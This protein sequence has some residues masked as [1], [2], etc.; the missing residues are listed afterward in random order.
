MLMTFLYL[1]ALVYSLK[2]SQ[3]GY[4]FPSN[5]QGQAMKEYVDKYDN[6]C[7]I[8]FTFYQI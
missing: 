2:L 8:I 6:I 3:E 1:Q 7:L 4:V 5:K